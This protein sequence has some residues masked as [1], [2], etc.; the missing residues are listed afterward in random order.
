MN[1][2]KAGLRSLAMA[3]VLGAVLFGIACW[4][5]LTVPNDDWEDPEADNA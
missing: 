4:I 5:A 2:I 3:F 1:K